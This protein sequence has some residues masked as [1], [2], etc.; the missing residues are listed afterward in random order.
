MTLRI[1]DPDAG[2]IRGDPVQLRDRDLR[3]ELMRVR[4]DKATRRR[5]FIY[6]AAGEPLG[7]VTFEPTPFDPK[8]G[9]RRP[10]RG[11]YGAHRSYR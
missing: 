4:K 8:S 6:D 1:V 9:R 2:A 11:V 7:I 10:Y 5:K 3:A